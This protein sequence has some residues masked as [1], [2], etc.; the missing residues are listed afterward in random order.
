MRSCFFIATL[1]ILYAGCTSEKATPDYNKYPDDI[2]ELIV[3]KC[4]VS[5]CHDPQSK[6]AA[7]GLALNSWENLFKGNR[8]GAVAIPYRPDQSTLHFSVN[9]FLDL[10]VMLE[11]T[12]PVNKPPLSLQEVQLIHEWILNGAPNRNGDVKFADN[13]NRRKYYVAN[14]GCDLVTVFDAESH[15]QMRCIDVG[16][17]ASTESPH[18]VRVS[19]DGKFW[20]VIFLNGAVMQK[21]STADDHFVGEITIG[22]G[23]WNTMAMTS[24]SKYAFVV[25][26]NTSSVGK[27]AYVNLETLSLLDTWNSGAFIQT[28]GSAVGPTDDTLYVTSQYSNFIYKIPINDPGSMEM[29]SLQPG[30]PPSNNPAVH[31]DP[32]EIAFSPDGSKYYVTCQTSNEVRV[33][34]TN[35]DAL[36]AIIPTGIYPVEMSFSQTSN[37]MFVT[38]MEDTLLFPGKRGAVTIINYLTDAVYSNVFTGYQPHG[39]IVDD[40]TK[41]VYVTNRNIMSGGPAPHHSSSC[42][43]RNGYVTAIDMGTMQLVPGFKVEVSVDPYSVAIRK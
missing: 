34:Q 13:P 3:T 2:G 18:M 10:G 14:Q 43:G 1:F 25:D 38:C 20:Y 24:D 11:P 33:M 17:T 6:D 29:I 31:L 9:T 42:V 41:K 15:I 12:M 19:P 32:H 21:Y 40:V 4:A 35:G 36:L 27:I 26:W 7:S 28:H 23:N 22:S 5:G 16:K 30:F 37:Y 8:G 39:V